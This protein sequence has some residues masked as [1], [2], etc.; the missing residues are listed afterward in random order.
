MPSASSTSSFPADGLCFDSEGRLCK[1]EYE[2]EVEARGMYLSR[3]DIE[4]AAGTECGEGKPNSIQAIAQDETLFTVNG[5]E[6]FNK[7][8][9]ISNG[10]SVDTS[11][12]YSFGVTVGASSEEGLSSNIESFRGYPE[13]ISRSTGRDTDLLAARGGASVKAPMTAV[14]SSK[15]KMVLNAEHKTADYSQV[16]G[17]AWDIWWVGLSS[18]PGAGVARDYRF[19]GSDEGKKKV[20]DAARAFFRT[21]LGRDGL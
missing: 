15:G 13:S 10:T 17:N 14:L 4:T 18:C 19:F 20:R 2:S 7:A 11:L 21:R 6:V 3:V 12:E 8:V 9:A 5:S 16:D 1:T